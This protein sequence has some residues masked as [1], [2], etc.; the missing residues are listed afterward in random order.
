MRISL[1]WKI[2]DRKVLDNLEGGFRILSVTTDWMSEYMN[3]FADLLEKASV[4]PALP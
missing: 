4:L 1:N 2:S 3:S